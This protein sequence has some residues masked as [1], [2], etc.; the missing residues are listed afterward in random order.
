[1]ARKRKS[2]KKKE[3]KIHEYSE[4][5]ASLDNLDQNSEDEFQDQ[6]ETIHFG[7]NSIIDNENDLEDHEV[8]ALDSDQDSIG[9]EEEMLQNFKAQNKYLLNQDGSDLDDDER[10]S[11]LDEGW[12][13]KRSQYYQPDEVSSDDEEAKEEEAE[14]LRLQKKRIEA[15]TET[16]FVEEDNFENLLLKKS[17]SKVSTIVELDDVDGLLEPEQ[18]ETNVS[19]LSKK[20]QLQLFKSTMPDVLKVHKEFQKVF[21]S[22]EE[23]DDGLKDERVLFLE[24]LYMS[25]MAFYLA[26][27]AGEDNIARK[28]HPVLKKLEIF[29]ELL[30]KLKDATDDDDELESNGEESD[31]DAEID[32]LNDSEEMLDEDEEINSEEGSED[33]G[34]ESDEN[35][36]LVDDFPVDDYEPIV[37]KKKSKINRVS[38]PFGEA[39]GMGEVDLEDKLMRKKSLQFHV[40]RVD[41]SIAKNQFVKKAA[42][43]DSDLPYKTKVK[44]AEKSFEDGSNSDE[45]ETHVD[46]NGNHVENVYGEISDHSDEENSEDYYEEV[47]SLK[48]KRKSEREEYHKQLHESTE[49]EEGDLE[50]PNARRKAT[51]KILSN[52]GLTP[53]RKKE[54]KNPRVKKRKKY[55]KAKKKLSSFRR[56]AVDKTKLKGAYAGEITGINRNVARSTKF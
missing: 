42:K 1:M 37:S 27:A 15:F 44:E 31:I 16:D 11:D 25:N 52:R 9:E 54:D 10:Q 49:M 50:D 56:V 33:L 8:F 53:R 18:V 7:N 17:D 13:K 47:Q 23:T 55:E 14:A 43:G 32:S 6:R 20:E 48:R 38:E 24:S 19:K 26:L 22:I 41:Q 21:Q 29:A 36:D 5:K 40:N 35:S 34:M 4:T 51:Y 28:S 2:Q 12:G 3:Q 45:N 46:E 39:D 30:L